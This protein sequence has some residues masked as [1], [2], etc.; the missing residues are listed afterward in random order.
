MNNYNCNQGNIT[1]S[2]PG[3]MFLNTIMMTDNTRTREYSTSKQANWRSRWLSQPTSKESQ[4]QRWRR[5]G[6]LK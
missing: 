2:T 3:A 4:E 5:Q 6:K 1:Q